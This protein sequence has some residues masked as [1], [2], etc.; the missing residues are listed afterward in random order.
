MNEEK[1][2]MPPNITVRPEYFTGF[3]KQEAVYT[4]IVGAAAIAA[5]VLVHIVSGYV[6]PCVFGVLVVITLTVTFVTKVPN[7][8]NMSM[9]DY[10]V[11]MF[12]F[13]NEQQKFIYHYLEETKQNEKEKNK[14]KAA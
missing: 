7:A 6:V 13:K 2:Y 12:K 3:G 11:I 14:A 8:N 9:L 5:A 1:L 4:M 10:T